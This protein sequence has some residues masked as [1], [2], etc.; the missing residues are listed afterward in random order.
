VVLLVSLGSWPNAA[1]VVTAIPISILATFALMYLTG[2]SLNIMSLGGLALGVGMLVDN[3]V[4]VLENIR[5]HQESGKLPLSAAIIKGADQVKL[6]IS[7]STLAHIIV[8]LP[9]IFVGGLAGLLMS[10]LALTI[11][12]ALLASLAVSLFFN[13]M[14]IS[15]KKP[16]S[17]QPLRLNARIAVWSTWLKDRLDGVYLKVLTKSLRYPS[18]VCLI[19]CFV[20]ALGAVLFFTLERELLPTLDQREFFLRVRTSTNYSYEAT[21]QR[22]EEIENLLLSQPGVATVI[23]QIGYNPTEE[24]EKVLQEREPEL[25]RYR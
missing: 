3:G 10:Q 18:R 8:F 9:V 19:T 12:F 15:L 2:I 6:A 21:V 20:L 17:P 11:S 4:V 14:L 13:T 22:L 25:G 1:I 5:R 16:D 7:S 24:Y 23:T